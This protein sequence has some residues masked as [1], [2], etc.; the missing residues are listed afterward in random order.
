MKKHFRGALCLAAAGIISKALGAIYRI[1]LTS[2][3]GA[4]GLG[5]YQ[6]AFPLYCALLTVS[7][8]G[9]PTALS[10]MIAEGK[11]A[12]LVLK[13]SLVFFGGIGGIFALLVFLLAEPIAKLQGND[14][15]ATVYR[16]LS[17]SI[18]FVSVLSA[19]RGY[20]QGKRRYAPTAITQVVEQGVK[21]AFGLT[22]C[23]FFGGTP[24]EKAAV[25]TFAVTVSEIVALALAA[26]MYARDKKSPREG[27]VGLKSI[28]KIVFP[29]TLSAVMIPLMRAA[30]GFLVVNLLKEERSVAT[31][32][33][34]LYGGATESI[35]SLPVAL[36][37]AFA[38]TSV[39]EIASDKKN[40]EKRFEPL[41]VTFAISAITGLLTYFFADTGVNLVYS[42]LN[43]ADREILVALVRT[44][45]LQIV[46]LS[47]VQTCG[48]V[49]VAIDRP[50][51]P[52]VCLFLGI[53]L[54]IALSV[55]L[56]PTDRG[57][58]ACALIDVIVFALVAVSELFA[59]AALSAAARR[60]ERTALAVK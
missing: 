48:A 1:P 4:E 47:L 18:F 57:I 9:I 37:Y 41:A 17:P 14:G 54:K 23:V 44:A 33:Y 32:L 35:I 34:G 45:S 49:L 12:R 53:M 52:P 15:V 55:K 50:F 27:A 36:S 60:N 31:S 51:I 46:G 16:T 21:I 43:A 10:K 42:R 56:I 11:N 40:L 28:I 19:L 7:S 5:A 29:I 38:I 58:Y 20:F 6:M 39:P 2:V 59:I 30:D 3:L 26:I 13:R 22:L 25:A 8:T 24:Y